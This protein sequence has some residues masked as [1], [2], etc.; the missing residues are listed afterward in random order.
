M[1]QVENYLKILENVKEMAIQQGRNPGDICVIAVS[2]G[3]AWE[4]VTPLIQAGC[5]D[6]GE[7]RIQEALPKLEKTPKGVHWHFI[8]PLQKNKVGKAIGKFHLIHSVDSME[9]AQMISRLSCEKGCITPILLQANTSGEK[10][11]QGFEPEALKKSFVQMTELP[12]IR[13]EGFMT[14]APLTEDEAV[15][16]QCFSGLRILRDDLQ[17]STGLSLPHLSMGMSHDYLMAIAEGATLL[18]IGSAIFKT[19]HRR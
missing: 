16:R 9:L 6:F 17:K 3:I 8:G 19:I 4:Q 7:N 14:I 10:T 15:I 18:R 11:K 12:G 13:I 5:H 2:K 1:T